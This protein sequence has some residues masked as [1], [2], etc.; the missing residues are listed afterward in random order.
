MQLYLGVMANDWENLPFREAVAYLKGLRPTPKDLFDTL[1][2]QARVQAFTVSRVTKL[3]VLQRILELLQ[4][5]ISDGLTLQEFLDDL[6]NVNLTEAHLETVYR[7]NLQLAYGYGQW[8]QG[9]DSDL[10]GEIWGWRY[11]TVGDDRVRPAHADLDKKQFQLG[12]HDA[13]FPPWDFNDRCSSEWI[14]TL[15][16]QE[17]RLVTDDLPPSVVNALA[18]TQFVSPAL[19]VRYVPDLSA[20]DV[21]LISRFVSDQ[22]GNQ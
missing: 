12:S 18:R 13:V 9:T 7:T 1:I 15:E 21:G 8:L 10:V 4:V 17:Q 11:H 20:Y 22:E 14:T 16:A 19:G 3:N 5:A 2:V 6:Q